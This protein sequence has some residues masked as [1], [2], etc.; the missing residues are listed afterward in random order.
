[1]IHDYQE[2]IDRKRREYGER[3]SDA[4]LCP[5]FRPYFES[6]ARIEVNLDGFGIKRGR[7]GI[8]SGWRPCFLLMLTSRS[9]G[10]IHT[11]SSADTILR[12]VTP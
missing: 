12:V 11:L 7:I 9:Q 3:F 4:N 5:E 8:T 1:M 2:Y 6:Q 10:S